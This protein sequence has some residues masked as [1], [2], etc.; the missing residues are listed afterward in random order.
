MHTDG[1]REPLDDLAREI[2]GRPGIEFAGA[3]LFNGSMVTERATLTRSQKALLSPL[4]AL[5]TR[6]SNRRLFG[7]ADLMPFW[8]QCSVSRSQ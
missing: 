2:E 4:G 7:R 5:F 8:N 6:L 3:L 1:R